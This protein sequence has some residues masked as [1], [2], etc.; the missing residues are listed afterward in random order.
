[1]ADLL[2]MI[3]QL[4]VVG[5]FALRSVMFMLHDDKGCVIVIAQSI[6]R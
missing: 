1:M 2:T 3:R 6:P 5:K 4:K